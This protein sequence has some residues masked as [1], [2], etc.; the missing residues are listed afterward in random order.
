MADGPIAG[1]IRSKL[2]AALKPAHL[3]LIND[4]HKH[5]GHYARDGSAACEAGETHFRLEVVS[6]A[7]TGVPLVKRHQMVYGFLD[8]EF[9]AGLHALAITTKTPAEAER[10]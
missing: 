2:E 6:D 7:F 9:K 4:S 8:D 10:K 1:A 5:A 3:R